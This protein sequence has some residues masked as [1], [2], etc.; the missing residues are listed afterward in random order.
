MGCVRT[1]YIYQTRGVLSVKALQ[2]VMNLLLS[3]RGEEFPAKMSEYL[4]VKDCDGLRIFVIMSSPT[5]T[6]P[7]FFPL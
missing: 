3:L 5:S 6:T 2:T 4:L 1:D 7:D